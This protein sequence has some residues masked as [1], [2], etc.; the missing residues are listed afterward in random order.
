MSEY[1]PYIDSWQ[2]LHDYYPTQ[3]QQLQE[4]MGE[5]NLSQAVTL[6]HNLPADLIDNELRPQVTV[7]DYVDALDSIA[8][9]I[10]TC[11]TYEI[12]TLTIEVQIG[13][14]KN[15]IYFE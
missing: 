4:I 15:K 9:W 1:F 8:Y 2:D 5:R 12:T 3:S 10:E 14:E 13:Y 6:R 7:Y 11:N